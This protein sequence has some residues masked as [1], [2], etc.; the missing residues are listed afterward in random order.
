[1]IKRTP[2]SLTIFTRK[3]KSCYVYLPILYNW[4]SLSR[5]HQTVAIMNNC[6]YCFGGLRKMKSKYIVLC[7]NGL[8]K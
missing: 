3:N 2:S 7:L 1:M 4:S 6:S 5:D 8:A